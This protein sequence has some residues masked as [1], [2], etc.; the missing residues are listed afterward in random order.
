MLNRFI[1]FNYSHTLNR[2]YGVE[3]IDDE[4]GCNFD[5]IHGEA[6]KNRNNSFNNIILGIDEYLSEGKENN[7]L[8]FIAYKK[9]YQ[10]IYK[11]TGEQSAC[12]AD[13]IKRDYDSYK[14]KIEYARERSLYKS[15]P[16]DKFYYKHNLIPV[17]DAFLE[18]HNLYIFGHSLD[19]TDGDMLRKMILNDNVYT[20]IFYHDEETHAR[21]I[22]NLVKVI[23]QD[24]L[25]RRTGGSAKTI[26][27]KAQQGMDEIKN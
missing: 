12:W 15:S 23:H 3:V 2:V 17:A 5:F 8:R 26:Q 18:R 20:T 16:T 6:R 19:D 13:E 25:I 27:F 11:E 22:A 24:E 7:D 21:Q 1:S 4:H 10:R 9:Y 14:S